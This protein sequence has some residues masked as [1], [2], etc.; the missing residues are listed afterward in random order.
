M[1]FSIF[2]PL[3]LFLMIAGVVSYFVKTSKKDLVGPQP[4]RC[5]RGPWYL[6]GDHPCCEQYV[7][8]VRR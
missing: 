5:A 7:K 8:E 3:G 6:G 1:P 2:L 4:F